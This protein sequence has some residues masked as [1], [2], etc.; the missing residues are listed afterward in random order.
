MLKSVFADRPPTIFFQYPKACMLQRPDSRCIKLNKDE[1]E[2]L[3]LCY[4]V[5]SDEPYKSVMHAFG[6]AGFQRTRGT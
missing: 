2:R 6:K 1:V 4:K 3:G 5:P